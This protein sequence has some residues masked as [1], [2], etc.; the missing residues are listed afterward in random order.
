MQTPA[1]SLEGS[2][3]RLMVAAG[4]EIGDVSLERRVA[5]ENVLLRNRPRFQRMAT[6]WL[7]NRED[8]EDAVQDAMLSAF[9]NIARFEGRA[10][11]LTWLTA[12]VIN[13]V[14][15]Q[16]RRRSRHKI[17]AFDQPQ[18]DERSAL[19]ELIADPRPT[20]EQNLRESEIQELIIKLSRG[21]TASQQVAMELCQR[22]GLSIKEAAKVLGVPVGTLKA[23]LARGRVTLKRRL[24][25]AIAEPRTRKASSDHPF[26]RRIAKRSQV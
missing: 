17:I 13:A 7:R 12:I 16:I 4:E 8:A 2:N 9:K 22:D 25:K 1:I 24:R 19:S 21:L 5:F 18:Q 6:H 11:M 15:M 14:R 20:P 23:Q 3:I 26:L 10:Q